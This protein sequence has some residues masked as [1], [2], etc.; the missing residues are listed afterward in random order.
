M[1]PTPLPRFVLGSGYSARMGATF[2]FTP[3]FARFVAGSHENDWPATEHGRKPLCA[4]ASGTNATK[5]CPKDLLNS[6]SL[7]KKN[8]LSFL[9]G[10][11]TLPPNWFCRNDGLTVS[12][13]F[14][15]SSA[16]LR[17]NSYADPCSSF[18]PDLLTAFTTAPLPPNS[19]L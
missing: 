12:K 7:T 6:S 5:V 14:R 9:I 13:K 1:E 16:L 15:A 4:F 2:E 17:R 8:S 11:P 18:V 3:T 19:A 10:P